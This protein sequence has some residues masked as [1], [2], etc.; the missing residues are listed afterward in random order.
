MPEYIELALYALALA[1]LIMTLVWWRQLSTKNAGIVDGWW[2]YNF[3]FITLLYFFLASGDFTRKLIILIPVLIW[4]IRLGS[5]LL[6]R[7]TSH[8]HEDTRYAKLRKEYGEHENFRMW[9][10]FIYQ[11]ISNVILT[12]PFLVICLDSSSELSIL[13]WIGLVIWVIAVIG[14]ATADQQLKNF[15]KDPSNKGK[16]CQTGLWNYSRHPNYFFEWL[17]WVGFTFI[18]LASPYGHLGLICPI[19]MYILLN[20]VT[21]IP[22][23]EEL[24][25]K[26]KGQDYIQYQ[27]TTSS[28]FPWFK[29]TAS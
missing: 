28:F 12:V 29:S 20:N 14:E 10:F 24:A 26:S 17:I 5:H 9:I 27:K 15:K 1:T 7:N 19:I 16:V 2:S 3:G 13:V 25:V 6:I 8:A 18:A 22:M 21:G 4:S 11:A 23:L